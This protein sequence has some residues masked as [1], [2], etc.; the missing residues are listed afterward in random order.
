M[1]SD[2]QKIHDVHT[3]WI[4]AVNAADLALLLTMMVDD[5]VLLNSG[6]VP[7]GRA[8]FSSS[9][10]DA[11]RRLRIN[12]VS[13]LEEVV[14]AGDVAY[15]RSRDALSVTSRDNGEETHLAG[16]LGID[17]KRIMCA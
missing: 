16:S 5:V 13:E 17:C 10:S 4:N 15:T 11:H 9:F 14:V 12:C 2:E 7:Y 3:T 6:Q 8:E 1:G